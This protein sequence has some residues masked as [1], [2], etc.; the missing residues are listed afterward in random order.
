[1]QSGVGD[2]VGDGGSDGDLF[3][4]GVVEGV[5]GGGDDDERQQQRDDARRRRATS[6]Q[7]HRRRVPRTC[8]SVGRRPTTMHSAT[9]GAATS[10]AQ[11]EFCLSSARSVERYLSPALRDD[12]CH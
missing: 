2:D 12:F 10:T 3:A 4:D 9:A 7:P 8:S 5:V 1:V 6:Q 11:P